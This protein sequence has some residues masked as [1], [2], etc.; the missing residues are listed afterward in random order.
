MAEFFDHPLVGFDR[1][2][3]FNLV[4][5]DPDV[6]AWAAGLGF[7]SAPETGEG[8]D[9]AAAAGTEWATQANTP[10]LILHSDL[11]LL[12]TTELT[13]LTN[14]LSEGTD[15]IAPSADGGT[16][17]IGSSG[18]MSF[19][20]GPGSF[21]RHLARLKD[22]NVFASVGLLHDVDTPGDVESAAKHRRGA[23]LASY[24]G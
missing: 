19:T 13:T 3:G 1:P 23:W 20:F 21:A 8:L 16:S 4:T 17:A 14:P 5:G 6:A 15:V 7:P 11:P 12:T 2:P 10:W 18:S 9:G 24:I 22:P